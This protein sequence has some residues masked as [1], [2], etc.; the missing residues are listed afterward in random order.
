MPA[1]LPLRESHPL[2]LLL[3][4]LVR[5][6]CSRRDGWNPLERCR[7]PMFLLQCRRRSTTT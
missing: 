6:L 3:L 4:L 5:M 2:L 7:N 1:T